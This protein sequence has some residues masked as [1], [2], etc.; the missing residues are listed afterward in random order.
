M[1]AYGEPMIGYPCRYSRPTE[2]WRRPILQTAVML[3]ESAGRW[4]TNM[5]AQHG[6]ARF[7]SPQKYAPPPRLQARPLEQLWSRPN[8]NSSN[9]KR[10]QFAVPPNSRQEMP[11]LGE[12]RLVR[13]NK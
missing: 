4:Q 7:G 12:R 9:R 8:K 5:Q 1:L 13:P 6:S 11:T 2:V 10:S 3:P